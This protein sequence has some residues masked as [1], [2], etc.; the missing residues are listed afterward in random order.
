MPNKWLTKNV[1]EHLLLPVGSVSG[2]TPGDKKTIDM[3]SLYSTG[4]IVPEYKR[5]IYANSRGKWSHR[6]HVKA[7]PCHPDSDSL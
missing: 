3:L 6:P 1:S 7:W 5:K 2:T 4:R